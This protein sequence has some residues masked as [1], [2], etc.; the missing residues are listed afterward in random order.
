M[1]YKDK[2]H[3]KSSWVSPSVVVEKPWGHEIRWNALPSINGKILYL[4]KGKQNSFKYNEA[5]NECLFVLKGEVRITYGDELSLKD[6]VNHPIQTKILTMGESLSVQSGCPYRLKAITDVEIIEIGD[7]NRG[8]I[9]RLK[10]D[11]DRISK[12]A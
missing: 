3:A 11:Y 5:K 9:I 6:P 7:S 2:K 10:D 1:S 8:K 12:R 4:E